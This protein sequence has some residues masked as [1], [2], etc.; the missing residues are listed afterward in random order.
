MISDTLRQRIESAFDNKA[1]KVSNILTY[2][3]FFLIYGGAFI[4]AFVALFPNG[5]T[6]PPSEVQLVGLIG[7]G[8]TVLGGWFVSH[9]EDSAELLN[10]ARKALNS[11]DEAS[12][13]AEDMYALAHDY[14]HA[15]YRLRSLYFAYSAGR[16]VL[17]QSASTGKADEETLIRYCLLAM[18]RDLRVALGFQTGDIWTVCVYRGEL[19]EA[20]GN[21]Y[22]RCVAHD[23]HIECDLSRARKW[24]SGVGVAGMAYAKNGEVVAP[25]TQEPSTGTVFQVD[26]GSDRPEDARRYRSMVAV[27]IQVGGDE[28]PWGVAMAT[29]DRSEH[30][31]SEDVEGIPNE[32]GVRAL[33]G[34]V[35]LA[36]AVCRNP[37]AAPTEQQ[38]LKKGTSD[39]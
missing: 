6:F 22:L 31:G 14:E 3:R 24:K 30:F 12:R 20:E 17:E 32:E 21:T 8:L 23:R 26:A 19:A 37:A 36:V 2:I 13:E 11:A 5:W 4:A 16:G 18:K 35:A 10:N 28:A 7:A 25:D 9:T 38:A 1:R 33:A 15:T 34:V 29:S 39:G 27:P